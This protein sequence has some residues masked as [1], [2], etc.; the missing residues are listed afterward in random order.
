M[1]ILFLTRQL[2][3]GGAERQLVELAIGLH[4]RGVTVAVAAFYSNGALDSE[5]KRAGVNLYDLGKSG[6]W[7]LLVFFF[8]LFKLLRRESPDILHG[9]LPVANILTVIFRFAVPRAQIVWGVRASNMVP[10]SY[11]WLTR[12]VYRVEAL[13]SGKADLIIA[14]SEAAAEYGHAQGFPKEKMV[15]IPNGIDTDRFRPDPEVGREIR[16]NWG[17]NDKA[18]LVGFVGRLDPMKGH[19]VFLR[20]AAN[21][22]RRQPDVQFVCVGDGP[23]EYRKT[24]RKLAHQLGLNG[25]LTWSEA[26]NDIS[27]TFNAFDVLCS[28]SIFGEGFPNVVGEAM[29]CGVPCVVADVGDSRRI[30]GDVGIVV[31]PD[32]PDA[33]A[34]ACEEMLGSL[35]NANSTITI[36]E[37]ARGRILD[38]YG[39]D[40]LIE[41]TYNT[42]SR[43]Q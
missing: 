34:W 1:K 27:A 36:G 28:S 42:L 31:E 12:M 16:A 23:T 37:R 6:R 32:D 7:D 17:I 18:R 22:A 8:R 11:D 2:G 24:L 5:L 9:Y 4:K 30:V 35:S 13:L 21:L 19:S 41:T 39:L 15:V 25:R 10:S 14:N 43:F 40:G 20:A 33:L 3:L 29:A 26:R 38:N